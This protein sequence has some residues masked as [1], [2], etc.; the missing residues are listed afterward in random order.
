MKVTTRHIGWAILLTWCIW[1]ISCF[2]KPAEWWESPNPVNLSAVFG[3]IISVLILIV[4]FFRVIFEPPIHLFTIPNPFQSIKE[5][6]RERR[7]TIEA[8][9]LLLEVVAR[10]RIVMGSNDTDTPEFEDAYR[11]ERQALEELANFE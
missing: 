11:K 9:T 3:M 4:G 2:W 6:L 7:R 1:S 8:K 5:V 10:E